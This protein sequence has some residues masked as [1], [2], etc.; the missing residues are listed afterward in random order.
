MR[1][2]GIRAAL[3]AIVVGAMALGA[4]GVEAA[5]RLSIS[6]WGSPKHYQV[7]E[8]VP[9][10]VDLLEEK[11]DGEIRTRVFSGGEMVQQQFV[12]S[13]VPQGTVDISLTTLDNW[14]GLI[15]D[16][17]ILTTPLWDKSMEW[18][19]D[20]LKQGSPIFQYYDEKLREEGAML[21]ALFDIGP[22]VM[23]VNFALDGPE[24]LEG[25]AIRVYSKGS[26]EV[27]QALGASP[28]IMG[29]GDVYS[30]LQRGT[31]DGAM[32]GLGGAV[33]LKHYEVTDEMFVPNGVL[34]TLIHAYVMNLEKFEALSPELQDVVLESAAEARD[35]MQQAA[36]DQ[37]TGL[38]D[39]VRAAGK[40]VNVVEPGSEQWNVFQEALAPLAEAA[41]STYSPQ[42]VELVT[43]E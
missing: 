28:T 4:T 12:A 1:H 39:E 34:G 23:S 35:A 37:L 31:V 22:P 21:L 5:E 43:G 15:A 19:R 20:N 11:S 8:F 41:R 32:G 42:I 26:G 7:T 29:V 27:M 30:G 18:T 24:D 14:S 33:G 2:V 16:V 38:L 25:K 36:I 17:G 40:E 10:F 3:A 9:R 6:T 13:A